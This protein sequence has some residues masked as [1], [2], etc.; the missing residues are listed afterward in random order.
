MN[1]NKFIILLLTVL[2][3]NLLLAPGAE[4]KKC[5]SFPGKRMIIR[6]QTAKITLCATDGINT[7][8]EDRFDSDFIRRVN[9]FQREISANKYI[10][11]TASG[12][13]LE[14]TSNCGQLG[15]NETGSIEHERPGFETA[16]FT[17]DRTCSG[18]IRQNRKFKV[19]CFGM[20][21]QVCYSDGV[22]LTG[23]FDTDIEGWFRK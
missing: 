5:I 1:K 15:I 4:A 7:Q 12:K 9:I 18:S 23:T 10:Y 11:I 3:A 8:C 16:T 2:L 14:V 17:S 21:N 20:T 22:C 6:T 13:E 19:G